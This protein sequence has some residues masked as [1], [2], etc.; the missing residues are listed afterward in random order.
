MDRY[1]TVSIM[2]MNA[3]SATIRMWKIAQIEPARMWPMPK[4]MLAPLKPVQAPPPIYL[5]SAPDPDGS[6]ELIDRMLGRA[7]DHAD[8][9]HPTGLTPDQFRRLRERLEA[10]VGVNPALSGTR[11]R[12]AIVERKPTR[13]GEQ[14]PHGRAGRPRRLVQVDRSLLDGDE[15]RL[16]IEPRCGNHHRRAVGD[17][18]EVADHHAEAVI[19]GHRDAD[20]VALAV[21]EAAADEVAV[22][23]DVAM[24]Q[25]RALR[26]AGGARGV[27]QRSRGVFV[28]LRPGV[29]AEQ[30][31]LHERAA[32]ANHD[33][34]REDAHHEAPPCPLHPTSV[35]RA[36]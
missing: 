27:A 16:R 24:R 30:Y 21:F 20:A 32:P 2:K 3:C 1:T 25:R 19:E 22:V 14:M 12:R 33:H 29:V 9:W 4:P 28:E 17:A 5:S 8:G 18:G 15:R 10:L 35:F 34:G 6:P 36:R 7:I 23:E 11:D 26:H 31:A 13:V